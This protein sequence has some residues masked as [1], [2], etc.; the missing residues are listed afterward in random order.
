[1]TPLGVVPSVADAIRI[2]GPCPA[3]APRLRSCFSTMPMHFPKSCLK[4]VLAHT[5][6]PVWATIQACASFG[7]HPQTLPADHFIGKGLG[8]A[9]YD[10]EVHPSRLVEAGPRF[11]EQNVSHMDSLMHRNIEGFIQDSEVLVVGQ[12]DQRRFSAFEELPRDGHTMFDLADFANRSELRGK[13]MELC[14]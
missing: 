2:D 5:R 8:P 11:I 12:S 13:L 4:A 10:R 1:M 9:L 3:F 7:T 14:G 6:A